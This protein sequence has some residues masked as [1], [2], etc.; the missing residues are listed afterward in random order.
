LRN[1]YNQAAEQ[2]KRAPEAAAEA[3][4]LFASMPQEAELPEVIEQIIAAATDAGIDPR[5]IQTINT[6]IPEPVGTGG[7]A[8]PSGIRLAQLILSITAVG[9]TEQSLAFMDNLQGLD[10]A[11][12]VTSTQ[13]AAAAE[14]DGT[15]SRNRQTVQVGGS[16]FVLQSQLPDL[17]ATVEGLIAEA[18]GEAV[19]EGAAVDEAPSPATTTEPA[20]N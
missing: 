11:L 9:T 2:A 15:R 18:Q 13:L 17:V 4:V 16:M 19:A 14:Q 10:R 3:Q 1:Q 20:P 8:D 7:T 5:D 6:T 12:L